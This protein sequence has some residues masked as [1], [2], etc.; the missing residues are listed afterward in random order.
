[1]KKIR[2]IFYVGMLALCTVSL[3]ACNDEETYDF[4]GDPY[5]HVFLQSNGGNYLFV[6]TPK[7][8]ISTLNFELPLHCNH[9]A[10]T[11]FSAR[12]EIDNSL[13]ATYN[14]ENGTEYAEMPASALAVENSSVRFEQGGL[15]SVEPLRITANETFSELRNENGYLIP[16]RVSSIEGGDAKLVEGRLTTYV[17]VNVKEDSDNI[18]DEQADNNV[19]GTLVSDRSGWTAEAPGAGDASEMFTDNSNYWAAR[20][21]AGG[22]E[23]PVTIN[24][25]RSYTFDGIRGTYLLY[26]YYTYASWTNGSKIE[27]SVDGTTWEEVG[28]LSNTNIIQV[29]Y[30]PVTGQYIRITVPA[31][32]SS[33][34]RATFNCGNFNIYAK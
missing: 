13:I 29:F 3:G 15:M 14:E 4:P 34:S 17:V 18:Y 20:A 16:L 6:H 32:S 22:V 33:W 19:T 27:V 24:L 10:T 2:N 23:M 8:S 5:T 9:R 7:L 28:V 12:V 25:G 30:T 21:S 26:G 1:M 31:P 11:P